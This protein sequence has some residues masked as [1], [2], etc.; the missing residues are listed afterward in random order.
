MPQG[1]GPAAGASLT[2]LL[3]VL[4]IVLLVIV[5]LWVVFVKAG[6]SGWKCLIPIYNSYI[7]LLISGKPGWWLLLLFIPVVG[8]VFHLLA[9]LTLAERFGRGALFGVGLFLLPMIF[10]PLLAFGG[11]QYEG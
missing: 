4:G 1:V 8:A 11:T 6:E 10:F 7:L 2:V 5:S 3:L 9:M